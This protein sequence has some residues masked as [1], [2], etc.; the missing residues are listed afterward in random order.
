MQ[1]LASFINDLAA[2]FETI[3]VV[4]YRFISH[5]MIAELL[6]AGSFVMRT[7]GLGR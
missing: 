4:A 6:P 7:V 3:L 1:Y 5:L 2:K